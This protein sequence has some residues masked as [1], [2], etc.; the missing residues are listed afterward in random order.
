MRHGK[1]L[2]A[3]TRRLWSLYVDKLE[4]EA[5]VRVATRFINKLKLPM[6]SGER[7]Q[8]YLTDASRCAG[9]IAAGGFGIH[10]ENGN[11]APSAW[12]ASESDPA[13]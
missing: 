11:P 9:R 13:S 12:C 1:D 4:P 7:F 8:D 10:A 2:V 3:E 6:T 5:I